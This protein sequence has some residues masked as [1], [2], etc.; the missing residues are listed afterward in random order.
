MSFPQ[1]VGL[2]TDWTIWQY[3]LGDNW[4]KGRGAAAASEDNILR[5]DRQVLVDK[6]NQRNQIRVYND[7][8]NIVKDILQNGA[9]LAI[10]SRNRNKAMCD[11]ALTY[12]N[13][14]NPNDNYNEWS[15]I[16]MVSYDE[17]VDES[18]VNHWKRIRGWSG[19]DYS[20]MLMF[21]DE[22]AHNSVRIEVGV[23]F[24]LARDKKGMYWDLYQEGLNAWRRAK[25]I[26][27]PSNP[28]HSPNRVLIGYSGLP[29]YWIWMVG[30]GEG[31]VDYKV[32]YRWGY[33]LYVADNI[34]IA[35]YFCG[36][37]ASW[38]PPSAKSEVCEVWVK[39]YDK[40]ASINKIWVPENAGVPA[41]T[42]NTTWSFEASGLSQENRDRA[43]AGYGVY[44]PYVLFSQHFYIPGMP[45]PILRRW[46]EM[47]IYTQIQRSLIE[48]V[49][50]SDQQVQQNTNPSPYPF[51]HQI[52]AW[53]ITV[54]KLT[55]AEFALRL[56]TDFR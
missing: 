8:A 16:H 38:M 51:R 19:S 14:P 2:D 35:K 10:S 49:P 56:E 33:A 7:I 24:Q 9:K 46:T 52:K 22:A 26:T 30:H 50:L 28:G 48:V 31:S 55:W 5:I 32:P 25:W 1:V 6:T 42:S 44:T 23:T 21:D 36:L 40:W 15:I 11:R 29:N 37:N 20:D 3:Y 39:D 17:I 45:A 34:W 13:A 4:G 27:I 41:Q 12:F 47:V 18:K 43:I 53:N 54:P